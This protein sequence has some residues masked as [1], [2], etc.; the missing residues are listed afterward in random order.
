M[1]LGLALK[2]VEWNHGIA[3]VVPSQE[4]I[5]VNGTA[6]SASASLSTSLYRV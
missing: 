2:N 1:R 4:N 3:F 6:T 5:S